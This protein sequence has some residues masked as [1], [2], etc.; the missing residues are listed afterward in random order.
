MQNSTRAS[1][2]LA[3]AGP[4]KQAARPSLPS[5]SADFQPGRRGL[6]HLKSFYFIYIY[7]FFAFLSPHLSRRVTRNRPSVRAG[8]VPPRNLNSTHPPFPAL[9]TPILSANVDKGDLNFR[10]K[11]LTAKGKKTPNKQT[12]NQISRSPI[13]YLLLYYPRVFVLLTRHPNAKPARFYFKILGRGGE[14]SKRVRSYLLPS[15]IQDHRS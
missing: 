11:H 14:N 1:R 8:S 7:I 13:I 2:A 5:V 3:R 4:E 6:S 10:Q 9:P 15:R 12:K